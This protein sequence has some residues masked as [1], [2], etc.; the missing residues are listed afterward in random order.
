MMTASPFTALCL[1]LFG[2]IFILSS[3]IDF[4][5]LAIPLNLRNNEWQLGFINSVVE[6]GVVPMLGIALIILGYWVDSTLN[7]DPLAKKSAFDLRLPTYILSI[8]L[9][10]LFLL[11]IPV[12]LGSLNEAKGN[13]MSQIEKGAGQGREQVQRF[14]DQVNA[15]AQN[16]KLLEQRIAQQKQI[17]QAGQVQGSALNPQQIAGLSNEV[18][19]LEGLRQLSKDPGAYRKRIDQIKAELESQLDKRLQKAETDATTQ[20]LKQ[21]LKTGLTSL[22]LSIGFAT[23]G[24]LGLRN[25]I[26]GADRR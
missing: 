19:Q 15:F 1:K 21:G 20:A 22:I 14:L 3:L 17:L 23:V 18:A 12:Y 6:R 8:L 5:T 25:V 7:A 11:V 26:S 24:A 10:L 2:V 9:G 13:A 4:L 16:P